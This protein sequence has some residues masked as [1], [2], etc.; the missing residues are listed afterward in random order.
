MRGV[1]AAGAE[2]RDCCGR[3]GNSRATADDD[4]AA[5]LSLKP[6]A[7]VSLHQL[8]PIPPG[9][10]LAPSPRRSTIYAEGTVDAVLFLDRQIKAGAA[11]KVYNMIDVLR[12]GAMR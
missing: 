1:A 6:L 9:P 11:K 7:Y 8:T 5:S 3:E 2:A 4:G 12:A 10:P